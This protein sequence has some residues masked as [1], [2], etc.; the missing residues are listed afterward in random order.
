MKLVALVVIAAALAVPAATAA[1][2]VLYGTDGP[3]FTITLK[4]ASGVKVTKL[5]HGTY[6]FKISDKSKIHNFHLIG[7]YVNKKTLTPFVGKKTWTLILHKGTY[8]YVC[9]IHKTFMKGS[10]IVT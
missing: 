10:F 5:R 9:D 6:I 1:T 2:P 8:R 4:K 3:G 7:P